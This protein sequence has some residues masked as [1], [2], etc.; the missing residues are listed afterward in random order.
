MKTERLY[1]ITLYLLNHGRTSAGELA[2]KFEV[3]VRTIQ[4]D[5][6][7]LCLA[8]IPVS[9]LPGALGGYEIPR[10]FRLDGQLATPEDYSCILTAL[11]GL[12]SASGDSRAKEVMEKISAVAGEN[13]GEM[14]LDF[15]VLREGDEEVL[16]KLQSAVRLKCSVAFTYTNNNQE[17]RAHCVE[18]VA[19]VYRWYSWY[20]LAYSP[21]KQD[22]RTY[23]LVRMRDVQITDSPFER[24][25]EPASVIL[26]K[27]ER[28][29]SR[30]YLSITVKCKQEA[31]IRAIE[32]LHGKVTGR[33][34]DG[35]V[36]MELTVVE[37]EQLWLGTLLSLGNRVEIIA[38][39]K[40]RNQVVGSA[41][42]IL[43]LYKKL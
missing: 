36:R 21:A 22:Y 13:S 25:H 14:V 11:R 27:A 28:A 17:T 43:S 39:E 26:E 7:S 35:D 8:G 20:L 1:A 5:M 15:S 16:Q 24:E 32:Y 6:D 40:I 34:E 37:N 19:V 38:P 30:K 4:R 41:E 23:K 12:V 3:S 18:P 10:S 33:Y 31:T 42:E 29:D 2:K 9:A